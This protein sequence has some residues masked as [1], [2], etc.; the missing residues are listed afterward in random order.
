MLPFLL[1]G[2]SVLPGGRVTPSSMSHVIRDSATPAATVSV[3]ILAVSDSIPTVTAVLSVAS[4]LNKSPSSGIPEHGSHRSEGISG[5]ITRKCVFSDM[6][7]DSGHTG[8]G[9]DLTVRNDGWKGR[10][11]KHRLTDTPFDFIARVYPQCCSRLQPVAV[12]P[13]PSALWDSDCPTC[14]SV[15][16]HSW[17]RWDESFRDFQ[18]KRI[19]NN[20]T[21]VTENELV[22]MWA[23]HAPL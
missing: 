14:S 15:Q 16:S 13:T 23:K 1:V 19:N 3:S 18:G 9:S 17:E 2:E 12:L 5:V 21:P 22:A 20:K 8:G 6:G 7:M 4:R 10:K 11:D